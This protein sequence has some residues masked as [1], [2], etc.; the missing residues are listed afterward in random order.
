MKK[1]S[2][3][4]ISFFKN[5]DWV[6]VSTLNQ[7]GK[8]HSSV[9]DVID[10]EECGKIYLIDLFLKNTFEN[11]KRNNLITITAV[12]GDKFRGY[13]LGGYGNIVKSDKVEKNKLKMWDE[14]ILKR[15]SKRVIGNIKKDRQKGCNP[16]SMLPDLQYLI[17][18][19]VEEIV[20]LASPFIKK[21]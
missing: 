18:V 7:A 11:L 19:N 17:E 10:V 3:E 15:I 16:E 6:I 21:K 4:L 1:L 12:D 14:K 13:A 20:N 5:Q 8:I 2:T 9:K